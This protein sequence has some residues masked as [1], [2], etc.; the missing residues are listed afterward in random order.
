[1]R[2]YLWE[3]TPSGFWFVCAF[4]SHLMDRKC[5]KC[6]GIMN[7]NGHIIAWCE[8]HGTRIHCGPLCASK[9]CDNG[10]MMDVF[11]A[12]PPCLQHRYRKCKNCGENVSIG[13]SFDGICLSCKSKLDCFPVCT[14]EPVTSHGSYRSD[15]V[16]Y[17]R[18][19]DR[20]MPT[21]FKDR[22]LYC[23]TCAPMDGP[24]K[25]IK[26]YLVGEQSPKSYLNLLRPELRAIV[27]DN[28]IPVSKACDVCE[29]RNV[30]MYS[31]LPRY[32]YSMLCLECNRILGE[33]YSPGFDE[34]SLA[35]NAKNRQSIPRFI[36][37]INSRISKKISARKTKG[38]PHYTVRRL[39]EAIALTCFDQFRKMDVD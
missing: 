39:N 37:T 2:R 23:I 12:N 34:R 20:K 21:F 35:A 36:R 19:L 26:S 25:A 3:G 15:W 30:P 10:N 33:W 5:S 13:Y 4:R 1:M 7:P 22:V 11:Y 32:D 9:S 27:A 31:L 16:S 38:K 29:R 14:N 18:E 24:S 17:D 6:T 28:I 8:C